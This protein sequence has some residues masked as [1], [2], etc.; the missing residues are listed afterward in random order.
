MM[1][2]LSSR[3]ETTKDTNNYDM[4]SRAT[5]QL[6]DAEIPIRTVILGDNHPEESYLNLDHVT[7]PDSL[8]LSE[9][10]SWFERA[11]Y[12]FSHLSVIHFR[13]L[14]LKEFFLNPNT[15]H[16][17]SRCPRVASGIA[18]SRSDS[19]RIS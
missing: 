14:C 8:D 19:Q 5:G 7:T 3:R 9:F 4:L 10:T 16:L 11:R 13:W 6:V 12:T 1:N 15:G 18:G 17:W 2:S